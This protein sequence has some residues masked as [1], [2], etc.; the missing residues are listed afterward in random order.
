MI[1]ENDD[2]VL[3]YV[4]ANSK[5]VPKFIQ[6]ARKY[7]KELCALVEGED[8]AQE[9]IVQ[10]EH[11]ES[12][13]KAE[14]RQK[15]SRDIRSFFS[16]LFLPIQNVFAATGGVKNYKNGDKQLSEQNLKKLLSTI[17]NIRDGKSI[18]RYIETQWIPLYHTD[19]AGVLWI[20]YKVEKSSDVDVY[21]TYQNINAIRNYQADGQLVE[22]IIFEPY[23]ILDKRYWVVVDDAK[24]YTVIEEG[25]F[26][27]MSADPL[28]TFEHPFG[29][30]PVIIISDLVDKY[31]NRLS[32][33]H[34]ILPDAKEYARDL[35]I[36]TIYKFLQGF[37]KHWMRKAIC[38]ECH[39]TRKVG[40]KNC[41]TCSPTGVTAKKDVTDVAVL[42]FNPDQEITIRGNDVMGFV[43]PDIETWKMMN[44]ELDRGE[45]ECY[46]TLWGLESTKSVTKTATEI[47]LDKQPQINK[48]NKYANTAEWIEWKITELCANII[49]LTKDKNQSISLIVY[50]RRYILEGIDTIQKKYEDAKDAGDNAVILDGI[51]DELITVKFKNDPQCMRMELLKARCEPYPHNS[52]D[53]INTYFGANEVARK[54]YFQSWWNALTDADLK[55][56]AAALKDL[57]NKAFDVHLLTLKIVSAPAPA[58]DPAKPVP[59]PAKS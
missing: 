16:R 27:T 54:I 7:S 40:D 33:I 5:Q 53:Q 22:N 57:F 21:P 47:Y 28:K 41:T 56:D 43:S 58:N 50:G 1:F 52:T 15:Y 19:P 30:A 55:K 12:S 26:F 17:S 34:D 39:G 6:D 44:E 8:F 51:F 32:P 2:A 29:E 3:A 59:D 46:E 49:D 10:I 42:P 11:L 36:K 14:A 31:G 18:E 37:P 25:E 9:L 4:K 38:G 23:V 45:D 20:Q 35:S 48:L 13:A 24:Q